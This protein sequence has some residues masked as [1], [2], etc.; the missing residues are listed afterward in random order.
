ME[1]TSKEHTQIFILDLEKQIKL[2]YGTWSN[3]AKVCGVSSG[4]LL[5]QNI[6]RWAWKINTILNIADLKLLLFE[7]SI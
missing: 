5:K 4:S 3:F 7:N 1:K 6:T 2:E